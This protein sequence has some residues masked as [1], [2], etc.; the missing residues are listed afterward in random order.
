MHHHVA[1]C[2]E[3]PF[4]GC[5]GP[6]SPLGSA[7]HLLKGP[8]REHREWTSRQP[9]PRSLSWDERP[10][11]NPCGPSIC[12]TLNL[13]QGRSGLLPPPTHPPGNQLAHEKMPRREV[14]REVTAQLPVTQPLNEGTVENLHLAKGGGQSSA[15]QLCEELYSPLLYLTPS[16]S[17]LCRPGRRACP[18]LAAGAGPCAGPVLAGA[19]GTGAPGSKQGPAGV[20]S[21]KV[22]T[23]AC[24]ALKGRGKMVRMKALFCIA[25]LLQSIPAKPAV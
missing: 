18:I 8:I 25:L 10:P 5:K 16:L 19:A 11:P 14:H 15:H 9:A 22:W 12:L 13:Y 7:E 6:G 3:A 4:L 17:P 23:V 24:E 2:V 1:Q 20:G 21:R